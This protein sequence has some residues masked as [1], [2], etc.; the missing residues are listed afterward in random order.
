[1]IRTWPLSALLFV[2]FVG[3]SF[4]FPNHYNDKRGQE[5]ALGYDSQGLSNK[6]PSTLDS[7]VADITT[8]AQK[9]SNGEESNHPDKS[10][11]TS[12]VG[13]FFSNDG[14]NKIIAIGTVILAGLAFLRHRMA[15]KAHQ[16][17]QRAYVHVEMKSIQ[18]VLE[19]N[20]LMNGT[21][22]PV[23]GSQI[24]RPEYWKPEE[25]REVKSPFW[26]HNPPRDLTYSVVIKNHGSTKA[27]L[28][29]S[30]VRATIDEYPFPASEIVTREMTLSHIREIRKALTVQST[31]GPSAT[32]TGVTEVIREPITS[33]QFFKLKIGK[34]A[35]YIHGYVGYR[36]IF[37][38]DQ[39]AHFRFA[40]LGTFEG[41]SNDIEGV[42]LHHQGNHAT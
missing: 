41:F 10:V 26:V 32:V 20:S 19:I 8:E 6:E 23:G 17:E 24:V 15:R 39:I 9:Q 25:N 37:D 7:T 11:I 13:A 30:N 33:E 21:R 3:T 18:S 38:V 2:A 34:A 27:D 36:D 42:V 4:S 35:I 29:T 22:P 1:M 14:A 40:H 5:N 16:V 28:L 12:K 31:L